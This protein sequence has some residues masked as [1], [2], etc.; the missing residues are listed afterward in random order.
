MTRAEKERAIFLRK[1]LI[2]DY[3]KVMCGYDKFEVNVATPV[4]SQ[5][6]PICPNC[7]AD[8]IESYDWRANFCEDCGTK[9]DW[10]QWDKE[11][12]NL[13]MIENGTHVKAW[14]WRESGGDA[15]DDYII[16]VVVGFHRNHGYS[17]LRDGETKE[18]KG[19][20][21]VFTYWRVGA[22]QQQSGGEL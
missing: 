3:N 21:I 8:F 2:A 4:L 13:Q 16:G 6:G 1:R 11:N 12:D 9:F 7:Y 14:R 19:K 18:Y 22:Y 15:D 17:V 20:P 10:Y 5:H